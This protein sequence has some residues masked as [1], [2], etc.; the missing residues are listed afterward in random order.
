MSEYKTI[1]NLIDSIVRDVAELPDR[2][3]PDDQPEIMLVTD[4]ELRT[5]IQFH[6][7]NFARVSTGLLLTKEI[8]TLERLRLAELDLFDLQKVQTQLVEAAKKSEP[9]RAEKGENYKLFVWQHRHQ[10]VAMAHARSVAEARQ[11]IWDEDGTTDASVP[12]HAEMHRMVREEGPTIFRGVTAYAVLTDSAEL[13]ESDE[14]R[15]TQRKRILELEAQLALEG[16]G[17]GVTT[18]LTERANKAFPSQFPVSGRTA[19]RLFAENL[20]LKAAALKQSEPVAPQHDRKNICIHCSHKRR[21]HE[22]DGDGEC[23]ICGCDGF[24][25]EKSKDSP[26]QPELTE[27]ELR[28]DQMWRI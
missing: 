15:E 7:E 8:S 16:V 9:V 10:F 13:E 21:Q 18:E 19:A 1:D 5:I 20:A 6:F 3:S 27:D 14:Y 24:E 26:K 22:V 28:G 4:T 25:A 23:E 11:A 12:I 17:V 2:N